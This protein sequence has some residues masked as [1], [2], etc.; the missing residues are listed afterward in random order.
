MKNTKTYIFLFAHQDDESALFFEIQE[1]VKKKFNIKIIYLTQDKFNAS[2]VR[3]AESANVLAKLGVK[4]ESIF[5]VGD[6]LKIPD[7][8]LPFF[9][10]KCINKIKANIVAPSH[11]TNIYLH[12]WEGGHQDHDSAHVIGLM[13]AKELNLLASTYQFPLYR[14][15]R[16]KFIFFKLFDLIN[17]KNGVLLKKIP[18]LNRIN[19]LSLLLQYPSQWRT[20]IGLY[21]FYLYHYLVNGN[22]VL[23]KVNPSSYKKRPHKGI[24]LYEFRNFFNYSILR[25][26]INSITSKKLSRKG[27]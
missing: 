4:Y 9:L 8:S 26:E 25:E 21:P 7:G 15:S 6:E 24:L 14:K 19:Y 10:L 23:Q 18:L 17:K 12:A 16:N 1:A 5:F 20:W 22:Q 11:N 3:N 2:S 13:L 27:R